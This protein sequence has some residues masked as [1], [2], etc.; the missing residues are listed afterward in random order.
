LSETASW[1]LATGIGVGT[2]LFFDEIKTAVILGLGLPSPPQLIA[3]NRISSK[4]GDKPQTGMVE[5]RAGRHGHFLTTAQL[6][7]Q[8][9]E[10]LVDTGASFVALTYEDAQ[11]LGIYVSAADFTQQVNTANGIAK[12]A[13]IVLDTISLGN[14]V[15]RNVSAAVSEPGRLGTTLLGMTFIGRLSRTEMRNGLLI[16]QE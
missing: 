13:P 8:S 1:L 11:R 4:A 10:V 2:V 14:I 5:I 9:V 6:N 3:S 7:G 12:I 15:L 16:L